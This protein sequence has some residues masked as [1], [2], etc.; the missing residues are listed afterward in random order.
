[1]G[2]PMVPHSSLKTASTAAPMASKSCSCTARKVYGKKFVFILAAITW[3]E[4]LCRHTVSDPPK[5]DQFWSKMTETGRYILKHSRVERIYQWPAKGNNQ[6]Q[7]LL[8]HQKIYRREMVWN[9]FSPVQ[10]FLVKRCKISAK[11]FLWVTLQMSLSPLD[12]DVY[13]AWVPITVL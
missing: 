9:I 1:M 6:R 4:G 12:S 7:T 5:T 13:K 11:L 2:H 8:R 10:I 3:K